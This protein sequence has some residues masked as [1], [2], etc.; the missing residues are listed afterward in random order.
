MSAPDEVSQQ[1]KLNLERVEARL[2]GA[3]QLAGRSR[4]E[5]T[6][7]AITKYV[8]VNTARML[9][10]LGVGQMGESRP[11]ALWEKAAGLP[12]VKWHL[13]GHMQRNKVARTLPLVHLIH[14]VDSQR[15]LLAIDEEA[16]KQGRIQDVLLELHLTQEETK[17]GFPESEWPLLP[18]YAAELKHV[19][20]KGLMG[21]SALHGSNDAARASFARLQSLRGQWRTQFTKPHD[22]IELSMGMTSDFEQAIQEGATIVRIGSALF[23][24]L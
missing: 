17:S 1:L 15:L 24:G 10:G 22:L 18:G 7:C 19:R 11:Q 21:M 9:K 3:C 12:D 6:F 2:Q 13:V 16:G 20:V 4:Q 14:S 23:E 5:V 8:D